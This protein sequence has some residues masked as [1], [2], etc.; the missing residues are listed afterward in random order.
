V[1]EVSLA[2]GKEVK[3]IKVG[4]EPTAEYLAP[5]GTLMVANSN[6]DSISLISTKTASV[7][8][9]VNVNPLPGSTVGSYP[10]AIMM[11]DPGHV[12]VSIG[13]D[14]ALAVDAYNGATQP[15]EYQGLLPTDFYPVGVT[16]DPAIGKIVVTNDKGIGALGPESTISKGPDTNPATGHNTYDDTGSITEFTMP[17]TAALGGYTHQV[18]V[19]NDWDH[20]LASTPLTNCAAAPAA[21]PARLGCASPIKHV[22][23]II[24]E[25]RT[26]DQVFGDIAKGNGDPADAQFAATVTPNAHALANDF[27]LF[28][29]RYDEG[30]LSADGHNWLVQAD[31][32]DYIER[33]FGAFYRSYP[34]QGGDALAYQRDG[35]IWND[36]ESAGK[37]VKS[38][39]E[40]NNF[41]TEPS[42]TPSWSEYYQDSQIM[43][44]KASGPLPVPP[45][46]VSTYADIPSLNAID[47]HAYPAFDLGIPDQYRTDIW[48]QSFAQSEKTGKLAGLNLPDLDAGRSHR[49]RRHGRPRPGRR[50]RGQRPGRRADHR[51]DLALAV[52]EGLGGVRGRGRHPERRGPRRRPPRAAD[53]RKP[54][55]QAR[56][57][58]RQLLHA[59][60]RGADDRADPRHAPD[61]PGGPGCR[62]DDRR[63]HRHARFRP[64]HRGP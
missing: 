53:D 37:T 54:V 47:D 19:D 49:G 40:Y 42:P 35:F 44:G 51:H 6:D 31:A 29:N 7:V 64:L 4:L 3:E 20:L 13:R 39:G 41:I 63:L 52:L 61:E 60:R 15:L 56:L 23:L 25:N 26:Y 32:N 48:A 45:S 8:Q 14:N 59:A 24:R 16:P 5:G 12:L 1:S 55:R 46:A 36:A 50:G 10:N 57:H 62:P 28:D 18:F 11:P 22:F 21:V 2:K 34:A 43:E 58:R 33:E 17:T 27:G 38:Y 9:T 30:T